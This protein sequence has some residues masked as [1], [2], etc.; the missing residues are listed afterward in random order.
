MDSRNEGLG[1]AII[2]SRESLIL[3]RNL[4]MGKDP[5]EIKAVLQTGILLFA[6]TQNNATVI[7]P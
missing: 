1:S 7:Y 4:V 2:S 3:A 6:T 5:K